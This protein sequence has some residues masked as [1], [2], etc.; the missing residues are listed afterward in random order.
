MSEFKDK[1]T[2]EVTE[3]DQ[4]ISNP[5]EKTKVLGII[6]EMI[7]DFTKHIVALTER[8]NEMEERVGEIYE[9]LSDIESELIESFSEDL[10]AEC[11]YC[12]ELIPL[13]L[14]E[15]GDIPDFECPICHNM[16]EM[17]MILENH[18][19]DCGCEDCDDCD[20][21]DDEEFEGCDGHCEHCDG[22]HD[23]ENDEEE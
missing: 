10:Q 9:M 18:H 6:Q 2:K 13:E 23:L 1:L 14:N 15:E 12:G 4:T 11:P 22:H 20:D 16:I 19:C 7:G 8:Q 3:I 21:E 17:E 5:E